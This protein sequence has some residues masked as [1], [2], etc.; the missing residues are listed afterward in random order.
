MEQKFIALTKAPKQASF[1]GDFRHRV[2]TLLVFT[3]VLTSVKSFGFES[4]NVVAVPV[5]CV[6][7]NW[8]GADGTCKPGIADC[9]TTAN[10]TGCSHCKGQGTLSG[11]SPEQCLPPACAG[12]SWWDSNWICQPAIADCIT[13]ANLT[14]C[15][16]CKGQGI[17]VPNSPNSCTP[18]VCTPT[19]TL[20]NDWI[21]RDPV[22]VSNYS[23]T[24]A[25][26][27]SFS[28]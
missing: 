16:H 4:G 15:S 1:R 17:L 22:V 21:C 8:V 10:L 20:G 24:Y 2:L 13:K 26:F 5:E 28:P 6:E 19:Q 25:V 12:L 7:P 3:A 9:I 18:P 27:Q 14:G 11:T 23:L